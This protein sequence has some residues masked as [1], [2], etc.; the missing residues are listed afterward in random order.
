MLVV[1]EANFSQERKN[2]FRKVKVC[3][4]RII[5]CSPCGSPPLKEH[6]GQVIGKNGCPEW[7]W[8]REHLWLDQRKPLHK[9]DG[10]L[11]LEDFWQG[12]SKAPAR[13]LH[14]KCCM[15]GTTTTWRS[16]AAWSH[17][18]SDQ[19]LHLHQLP[20][21]ELSLIV[22]RLSGC[23]GPWSKNRVSHF[24]KTIIVRQ[25][26]VGGTTGGA[27]QTQNSEKELVPR[28]SIWWSSAV[29][30]KIPWLATSICQDHHRRDAPMG[31]STCQSSVQTLMILTGGSGGSPCV[32]LCFI[33][34]FCIHPNPAWPNS[35]C[36][37]NDQMT[38]NFS[39]KFL[40]ADCSS[41]GHLQIEMILH[42]WTLVTSVL[43]TILLTWIVLLLRW[44]L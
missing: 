13:K 31:A 15:T 37:E 43:M 17:E 34:G 27:E 39:P 41:R 11:A 2:N 24:A 44:L 12:A 18:L 42:C 25:T 4:W 10:S 28:A 20:A 40:V 5:Q 38:W 36:Y 26:V 33:I 21:K 16:K 7:N 9:E 30:S 6:S 29:R 14:W 32:P 23:I 1:V 19:Y 8:S 22:G 3:L 35:P